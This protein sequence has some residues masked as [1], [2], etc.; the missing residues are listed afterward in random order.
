M[1]VLA[2]SKPEVTLLEHIK[3]CLIILHEL[4]KCFPSISRILNGS[5]YDFW[6]TLTLAI[7]IHDLGKAHPEFQNVLK[8]QPDKWL[9]QRHELFSI[10]FINALTADNE[11][12]EILRLV[13]AGHHKS[14]NDLIKYLDDYRSSNTHSF[15]QTEDGLLDFEEEFNKINQDQV[16]S[17]LSKNF[18]IDLNH[19]KGTMPEKVILGYLN[20]VE[21]IRETATKH[22]IPLLL[23]FGSLK[24]CDHLGSAQVKKLER[25]EPKDFKFLH[26][27]REQL[28]TSGKD[29]YN[30]QIKSSKVVGNL[31]LTAPT[32]SGKTESAMLWLSRQIQEVGQGRAFYVLPFTASINA[33]FE[34]LRNNSNGLGEE[35]VGMLHGKLNDY[36]F[37]YF[38]DFQYEQKS[39]R[40]AIDSLREKFRTI[41]SPLKI[42]TPFQLLKHLFG[43]KG[44]EQ[45]LL[46]CTGSYF[47]FDEIH[48]YNPRVFAQI[49]VLLEFI[50]THLQAKVMIMTATLPTFLKTELEKVLHPFEEIKADDELYN[51][52]D[53][54]KVF[55]QEGLLADN[56]ATI[57]AALKD[58]KKVLVVCNTV[59]ESQIVYA[60]L[61]THARS[62]VL[63]HS[64]FIGEDRNHHE[65]LLKQGESKDHA[66][67]LLVGT[68]AIEVSLDIDY[69]VIYT[70]PAPFD[71]L[72]QRFGRVNRKRSKG[73]CS[74]VVFAENNP[75][76]KFIYKPEIIARTISVLGDILTTDN[77][78]IKERKLQ[79]YI[80][81]VY[82]A[83]TKEDYDA[84]CNTYDLLSFSVTQLFPM[85]H[86]KRKEEEFYKQFEGIKVLPISL[87]ERFTKC[88]QNFDFIAAERLK[89]QIRKNKFAQLINAKDNNLLKETFSFESKNKL[90]SI[91][92]W[93]ITK[94]Y[95]P[96]LGLLYDEQEA[97]DDDTIIS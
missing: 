58:D 83:W 22:Y 96:A 39:K 12:K 49:K 26:Q 7:I 14:Y 91:E 3:D 63:L 85:V 32:G 20:K 10:P 93:V 31:I 68:Q 78:I 46:E 57:V 70:E 34:R 56:L 76:D 9:R 17:I 28:I 18:G 84:Y 41:Y 8:Q 92:F 48:A 5:S 97:W 66:I 52:F 6:N 74:V 45:G 11:T 36:L 62:S 16:K 13:V 24:H 61:R 60:Q 25:I 1:D 53:R 81:A 80:D 73:I 64:A 55:L 51:S 33:M 50:T 35:K 2:K 30:H 29:L 89:V 95:D 77:G 54:H 88:L 82:G 19:V 59:K 71:A 79:N 72:I 75:S 38:D 90:I 42:I 43:L 21:V 67:Q 87:K 40:E 23:L 47:I 86:S 4:Q 69:D 65:K 44:F 15:D 27:K 94:K 37:E